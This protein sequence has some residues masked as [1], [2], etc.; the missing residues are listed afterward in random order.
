[1]SDKFPKLTLK[2]SG[3]IRKVKRYGRLKLEG[4][5]GAVALASSF[6]PLL[7]RLT[8]MESRAL[9]LRN[10]SKLVPK[11]DPV[12]ALGLTRITLL[13]NLQY[14]TVSQKIAY[15]YHIS[16]LIKWKLKDLIL[17]FK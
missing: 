14:R 2:G 1:M 11:V 7:V 13:L 15:S 6:T 3:L 12:T 5:V 8:T 16:R 9:G 4:Q 10:R 17:I